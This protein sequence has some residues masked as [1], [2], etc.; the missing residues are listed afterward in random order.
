MKLH[1]MTVLLLSLSSADAASS[2]RSSA[3]EL[4]AGARRAGVG[5]VAVLPMA[6]ADGSLAAEGWDLSERL[7]TQLVRSGKVQVVERANLSRVMSEQ[8]LGR[9]GALEPA[10]LKKLGRLL[11][12][13]AV[14][15]GSFITSGRRLR[16]QA[17]LVNVETGLI[18]A[19]SE[20]E[21]DRDEEARSGWA[22]S[23]LPT[24]QVPAPE[25]TVAIPPLPGGSMLELRDAPN[26]EVD[27][28]QAAERVDA[29]ETRVLDLKARYWA[30][31]LR[32]GL[33]PKTLKQNPGSTI[34]DPQLKK[35]FYARLKSWHE[36][37][38]IP[39]LSTGEVARLVALD[40]K[41]FALHREC[42]L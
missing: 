39:E 42:G 32:E 15:T 11:S 14:V 21:A 18:M 36:S 30:L 6:P 41:A 34:T 19:A 24:M 22:K 10:G 1:W 5:T 26:D 27:C 38:A 2:I 23:W 3:L 16:L 20:A 33:D 37:D 40:G 8:Q 25:L 13:D 9:L 12:A 4:A 31:K 17:R 7:L 28:S 29:L 35:D